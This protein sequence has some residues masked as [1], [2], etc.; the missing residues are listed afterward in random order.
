MDKIFKMRYRFLVLL[1]MAIVLSA[2][3]YGFA[4][5]NSVPDGVAGEGFGNISGYNISN[6]VYTLDGSDPTQFASVAFTLDANASDVYAGLGDGS[7]IYWIDCGGGP[8]NFT[9]N[10]TGSTV[11]VGDAVE[12]HV[13]SVQ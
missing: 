4:A 6:V 8:L 11:S 2:A 7:L 13:S 5:A 9:C 3:T 12:L 10:L 1:V